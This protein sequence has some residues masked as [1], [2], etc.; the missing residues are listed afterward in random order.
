MTHYH[1]L[2]NFLT[3]ILNLS[4][5]VV[6]D[7]NTFQFI[8]HHHQPTT[9]ETSNI[10]DKWYIARWDSF[11]NYMRL[12]AILGLLERI[13]HFIRHLVEGQRDGVVLFGQNCFFTN[14]RHHQWWIFSSWRELMEILS[15]LDDILIFIFL[16]AHVVYIIFIINKIVWDSWFDL[17]NDLRL[18]CFQWNLSCDLVIGEWFTR[19]WG[20][21]LSCIFSIKLYLV[22][23]QISKSILP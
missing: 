22:L 23:S 3:T 13:T 7:H 9:M 19:V 6:A 4:F 20:P 8:Y 14:Y 5:F 11:S 12:L 15:H 2:V 17:V 16:F 18:L 21:I 1:A 10:K